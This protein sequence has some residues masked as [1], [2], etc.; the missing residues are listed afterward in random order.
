MEIFYNGA[1]GSVCTDGWTAASET[2]ACRGM[3]YSG[4]AMLQRFVRSDGQ[5]SSTN[6]PDQADVCSAYEVLRSRWWGR[7]AATSAGVR[8]TDALIS[9]QFV[10]L[11][12]EISRV[13]KGEWREKTRKR[14]A[15]EIRRAGRLRSLMFSFYFSITFHHVDI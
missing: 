2:V 5:N 13:Y 8:C 12:V 3:G 1:Y 14:Q 10:A 4:P 9:R 15:G 11:A 7:A 6:R